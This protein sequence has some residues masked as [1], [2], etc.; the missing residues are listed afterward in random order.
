VDETEDKTSA[1]IEKIVI[2]IHTIENIYTEEDTKK[3]KEIKYFNR[4]SA[5]FVINQAAS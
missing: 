1:Y 3:A 4:K 5:T 2:G